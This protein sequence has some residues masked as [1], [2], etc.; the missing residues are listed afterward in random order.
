MNLNKTINM[1]IKRLYAF[2]FHSIHSRVQVFR[3][4]K[5]YVRFANEVFES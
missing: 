1:L 4:S 5:L 2:E 3:T